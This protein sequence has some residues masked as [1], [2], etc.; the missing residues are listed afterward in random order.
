MEPIG[1]EWQ[2]ERSKNVASRI[3]PILAALE[4]VPCLRQRAPCGKNRPPV[5]ALAD[6]VSPGALP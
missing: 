5:G 6:F 1:P 3:L 2:I 4:R